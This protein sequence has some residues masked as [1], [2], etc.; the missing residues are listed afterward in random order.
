[1]ELCSKNHREVC[2]SRGVRNCPVCSTRQKSLDTI[3]DLNKNILRKKGMI[4]KMSA[5][6][7]E[8]LK[9]KDASMQVSLEIVGVVSERIAKYT[10]LVQRWKE[11]KVAYKAL[12][13]NGGLIAGIHFQAKEQELLNTELQEETDG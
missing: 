7:L 3:A 4:E 9:I 1:M 5:D 13:K 12:H 10:K 11:W 2:Y 6:Y 8:K